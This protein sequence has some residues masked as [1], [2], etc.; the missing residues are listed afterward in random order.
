MKTKSYFELTM[1][2][3]YKHKRTN[4]LS[5]QC[6]SKWRCHGIVWQNETIFLKGRVKAWLLSCACYDTLSGPPSR[7]ISFKNKSALFSILPVRNVCIVKGSKTS[8]LYNMSILSSPIGQYRGPASNK[9]VWRIRLN[10]PWTEDIK[11]PPFFNT[12]ALLEI[13]LISSGQVCVCF[14]GLSEQQFGKKLLTWYWGL[15]LPGVLL[16]GNLE[17]LSVE[18][19]RLLLSMLIL[20]YIT[21]YSYIALRMCNCL[22]ACRLVTA[23]T[24]SLL[25][26]VTLLSERVYKYDERVWVT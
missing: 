18:A 25:F 6:D 7:L 10:V 3:L 19:I 11:V 26:V 17:P 13:L 20:A 5:K 22:T 15:I 2:A 14:C 12:K 23:A 4:Q 21:L 9:R 1:G 8:G 16:I 24:N